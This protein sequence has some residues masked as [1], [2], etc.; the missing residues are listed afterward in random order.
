MAARGSRE[1]A[2][3]HGNWVP[4]PFPPRVLTKGGGGFFFPHPP[5]KK[6]TTMIVSVSRSALPI[7]CPNPNHPHIPEET[8]T[9]PHEI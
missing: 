6:R 2:T 8:G 3:G 4:L 9:T 1:M 7:M 5:P